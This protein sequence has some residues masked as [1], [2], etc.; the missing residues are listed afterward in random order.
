[1]DG[2]FTYDKPLTGRHF[3]GHKT[4]CAVLGNLLGSFEHPVIY[5]PPKSG[6]SSLI[7]QT[8]FNM[9]ISGR[10]FTAITVD[11]FP[12]RDATHFVCAFGSAVLRS[13][14]QTPRDYSRTLAKYLDGTHFVFDEL[15]YESKGE[16]VSNNWTLDDKDM[17]IML[18]MPAKIAAERNEQL[19]IIIEEFQRLDGLEDSESLMRAFKRA[20]SERPLIG[21]Q[22]CSFI[23]CGSQVNAMKAIFRNRPFFN[24]IVSHLPMKPVDDSL[25]VE[26]I[27]GGFNSTG[28]VIDKDIAMGP[29]KLFDNNLWYINHFMSICDSLTKGFVSDSILME[30]LGILIS[31]HEPRFK[32]TMEN[33]TG[34]QTR[35]LCALLD[36]E[37]RLSSS[38]VIRRYGLNSSANVLRVREALMKK[39]IITAGEKDELTIMD[40]LLRYWLKTYYFAV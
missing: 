8:L 17:A 21:E 5:E 16:I 12:A 29:G 32:S 24:G 31:I 18:R 2:P 35:F 14:C 13:V 34:H 28:K 4:E 36:G 30:A 23:L 7:S 40:P 39:E 25:V 10:R 15:R 38:E 20:L 33:L 27:R 37:T 1:M 26:H 11:A 19:I 6:K 22:G 3:I 9:K